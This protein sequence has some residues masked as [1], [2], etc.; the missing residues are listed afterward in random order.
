MNKAILERV[1]ALERE[2]VFYREGFYLVDEY[3]DYVDVKDVAERTWE[4]FETLEEAMMFIE[5]KQHKNTVIF[6]NESRIA[7]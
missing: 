5:S 7:D 1:K 2:G 3:D 6:M 4:T